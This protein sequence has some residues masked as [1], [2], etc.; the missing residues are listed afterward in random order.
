VRPGD[1]V[2]V[3]GLGGIG[4]SAVLGAV[5]AGARRVFAIDPVEWK[6]DKAL[7]L[8]ATQ[9]YSDV[10]S[11]MG[12]IAELTGGL[13]AT[14][15]IVAVGHVDGKDVDSW[16]SMTSKG[17]RCVLA[18]LGDL[19]DTDITANLAIN[20]LMQKGLQ[21]SLFGGGNPHHDIPLLASMYVAGKLNLDDLVTREY[22]LD[23]INEGFRDM[24]EGNVIRGVIRFTEEDRIA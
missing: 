17:G 21:G 24:L 5:S 8:G 9:S 22:R 20:I 12:E 2:A 23:Q 10:V 7:T 14:K 3:I 19:A 4:M 1:D 13:M 16:L 18:A 6:R 11:A 15:V